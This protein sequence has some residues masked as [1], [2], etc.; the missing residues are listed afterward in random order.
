MYYKGLGVQKNYERAL[1]WYLK[2]AEQGH[3]RAIQA[4]GQFD[5]FKINEK[6]QR[7]K[8][9]LDAGENREAKLKE[10][11]NSV[12]TTTGKDF[13]GV[14]LRYVKYYCKQCQASMYEYIKFR[15]GELLKDLFLHATT[16]IGIM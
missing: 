4:L 8:T 1:T 3:V 14:E 5:M 9:V 11:L 7:L 10:A 15:T 16:R 6:L 2:A 13:S 12:K